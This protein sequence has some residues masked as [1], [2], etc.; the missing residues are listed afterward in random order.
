MLGTV[1]L[2]LVISAGTSVKPLRALISNCEVW[3]LLA[4]AC[5]VF[6]SPGALSSCAVYP[7]LTPWAILWHRCAACSGSATEL[8]T[9]A[10]VSAGI[11]KWYRDGL[12]EA[13]C[14]LCVAACASET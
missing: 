4:Y 6:V 10:N 13:L 3:N 9:P 2:R 8:I 11:L 12:V 5:C 7:G 1:F 14:A